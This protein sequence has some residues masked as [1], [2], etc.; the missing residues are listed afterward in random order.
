MALVAAVLLVDTAFDTAITPLVPYYAR[1]LAM[2]SAESGLLV[3]AYPAGLLLFALPAGL[4]AARRGARAAVLAGVLLT[5]AATVAFGF[6]G[7]V[8]LLVSARFVQ[9]AGGACSWAG[10]LAWL[11]VTSPEGRRAELFGWAYGSAGLGALLGP[12]LGGAAT[13]VGTREI[14]S[15][16]AVVAALLGGVA[17]GTPAPA[18]ERG[19]HLSA[20]WRSWRRPQ[21]ARGLWLCALAGAG[22]GVLSVLV[23]LRMS[24]LGAGSGVV[25]AAFFG[26]AALGAVLS[27]R[28]GR[29]G[30]RRGYLVPVRWSLVAGA[31]VAALAPAVSPWEALFAAL[32]I[33]G[34]SF[35]LLYTPSTALVSRGAQS[36]R[37]SQGLIAASLN[38]VWSVGA[39]VGSAGGGAAA[40]AAGQWLPYAL[41]V[42]LCVG[43][44]AFLSGGRRDPTPSARRS[45]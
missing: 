10:A 1:H 25:A 17:L 41:L 34:P 38:V 9:G 15:G 14:F 18:P 2:S 45:R 5:G 21:I 42:G 36:A 30:D 16:A 6:S 33:G 20:L 31:A 28:V 4:L 13:A 37:I 22:E 19:D 32:V 11:A 35:A 12:V 3:A 44:L 43:T 39:T 26:A 40:G 23:P 29:M 24:A 27:P 7:S 8:P